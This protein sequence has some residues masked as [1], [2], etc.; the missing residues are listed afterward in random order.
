MVYL[1][2]VT[3]QPL[4]TAN[5]QMREPKKPLPPQTTI[6]LAA[7]LDMANLFCEVWLKVYFESRIRGGQGW[8][9]RNLNCVNGA[10]VS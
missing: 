1:M 6:F 3:S 2:E 7:D 5:L 9:D 4:A 8:K 10:G